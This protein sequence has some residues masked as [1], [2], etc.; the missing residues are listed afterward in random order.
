MRDTPR[1]SP[2]TTIV[3]A[4]SIITA[5]SL[6][7]RATMGLFTDAIDVSLGIGVDTFG[8]TIALQN[9]VWGL[10]QPLAGAI[11]DRF[12]AGRVL[13]VGAAVYAGG[14]LVM[15]TADGATGLHTGGGLIVGLGMSA[16][17]FAVVLSSIGK[18]VEPN[19]RSMALGIATAFGSFGHFLLV[20]LTRVFIDL[21]GWRG[22]MVVLAAVTMTIAAV[23]RPLRTGTRIA[24]APEPD[25]PGPDSTGTTTSAPDHESLGQVTGRALR[26]RDYL[27]VNA[28]FFV[29]GFHVTFV[30]VHLPKSLTD[31]GYATSIATWSLAL[32]GLFNIFGAFSAGVLGVRFNKSRLLSIIYTTRAVAFVGLVVLPVTPAVALGFGALLGVVWLASVPLTSGIVLGQFGLRNAGT[33]FGFV[34]LSHQVGAFAGAYGGGW[35]REATGSYDLWWWLAA[36]L[37]IGA[38]AIHFAISERP[39]PRDSGER[40]TGIQESAGQDLVGTR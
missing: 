39:V 14:L 11:A 33:L 1:H 15:A 9:L 18:L 22:S 36:I 19:Q 8:L 13:I 34:F 4:G 17:S 27:L 2:M 7:V 31:A 26:H 3:V 25:S 32:I 24:G 37:S 38:A 12:G 16:A 29:C 5:V 20:P 40:I 6:G 30:G 10:S 28:A 35:V 23:V 21:L